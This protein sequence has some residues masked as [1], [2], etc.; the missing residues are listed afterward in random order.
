MK[1]GRKK[2]IRP[3]GGTALGVAG[4]RKDDEAG[5]IL[6]LGPESIGDPA[7]H[8]RAHQIGRSS[9]EK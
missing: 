4:A 3:I 2:A 5:E 1:I 6:V 7:P 9:I 8:R